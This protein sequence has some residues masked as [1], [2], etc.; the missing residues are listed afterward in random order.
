MY[1]SVLNAIWNNMHSYAL[2]YLPGE[3]GMLEEGYQDW[4]IIVESIENG[5]AEA[6]AAQIKDHLRRYAQH[7]KRGFEK[8]HSD[9]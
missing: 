5:D 7:Y 6:A 9:E 3:E 4:R 1:E 2:R 8:Y